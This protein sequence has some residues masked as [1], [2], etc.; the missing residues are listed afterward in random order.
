MLFLGCSSVSNR[1]VLSSIEHVS[2]KGSKY[3]IPVVS[4][5]VLPKTGTVFKSYDECFYH[6]E[7]YAEAVGFD[8][9][10]SSHN[11]LEDKTVYYKV[12]RCTK[13]G[14]SENLNFDSL[15]PASTEVVNRKSSSIKT[16]CDASVRYKLIGGKFVLYKFSE[17]HNHPLVSEA[18][19]NQLSKKMKLD[20]EDMSFYHDL[21]NR[22]NI[23]PM[24]AHRLKCDISGDYDIVG[25][26]NVDFKN[27]RRDINRYIGESDAHIVIERLLRKKEDRPNFTCEYKCDEEGLLLG[28]FWA[29]NISKM[30]YQEFGDIICF[31][32]TYD[33]NRYNMK[34]V[35]LT[36]IDNHKRLV[37]F[38]AALL[39][40]ESIDSF[41]WFVD[42]FLNTSVKEPT[43][44]VTDQDPV[45]KQ[46][47]DS[48]FKTT[49]HGLCMWYISQN[50][51]YKVGHVLFSNK[52]FQSRMKFIFWSPD[53]TLESFGK[54]WHS[55]V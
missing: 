19:K 36:G 8:A 33:T 43:L 44:V 26:H 46:A 6:Y 39:F 10:K 9:K 1:H 11:R 32:A 13:S 38:G 7:L 12:C 42:A 47:I 40:S 49:L 50:F 18:N 20:F 37:I 22:S 25:P 4:Y 35:P 52:E 41:K 15:K 27:F 5:E 54:R 31:D 55:M 17:G 3:W 53:L 34:F 23:G 24:V 28:V 14:V 51:V 29:D 21:S 2:P 48:N 16:G 30:N 45:M